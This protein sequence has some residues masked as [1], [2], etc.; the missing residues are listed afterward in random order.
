VADGGISCAC[1]IVAAS[2]AKLIG[3]KGTQKAEG[4][5]ADK[6]KHGSRDRPAGSCPVGRNT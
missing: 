1:A 6:G 3:I 5:V 4:D 2:D